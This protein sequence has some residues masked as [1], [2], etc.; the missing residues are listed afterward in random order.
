VSNR[1]CVYPISGTVEGDCIWS[2]E[3][4][5]EAFHPFGIFLPLVMRN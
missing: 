1:A 3:V 4:T 5:N 2:N